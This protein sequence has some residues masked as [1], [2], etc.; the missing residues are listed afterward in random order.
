M[1]EVYYERVEPCEHGATSKHDVPSQ[2]SDAAGV[3]RWCSGGSR[4]RVNID[5]EAAKDVVLG[6]DH[7][8]YPD[9]VEARA[10]AEEVI[11]AALGTRPRQP[12]PKLITYLEG[13]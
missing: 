12:D 2:A 9:G 11:A 10:W 7:N 6:L 8:Y 13:E 4:V 5:Y 3:V 1:A